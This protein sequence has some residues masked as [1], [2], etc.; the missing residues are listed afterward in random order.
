MPRPTPSSSPPPLSRSPAFP[1]AVHASHTSTA[2]MLL[3]HTPLFHVPYS[4]CLDRLFGLLLLAQT[5]RVRGQR[6]GGR[7]EKSAA[8]RCVWRGRRRSLVAEERLRLWG[9]IAQ[10]RRYKSAK[11]VRVA[12]RWTLD[13]PSIRVLSL[14]RVPSV[15]LHSLV[16][17]SLLVPFSFTFIRTRRRCPRSTEY[18]GR[19]AGGQGSVPR[20]NRMEGAGRE[21]G[22]MGVQTALEPTE[23]HPTQPE[24][25]A[26]P[27]PGEREELGCG[28]A[29]MTILSP[30]FRSPRQG[31]RSAAGARKSPPLCRRRG[32]GIGGRGEVQSSGDCPSERKQYS[33]WIVESLKPRTG[34]RTSRSWS[35]STLRQTYEGEERG[36]CTSRGGCT[37]QRSVGR[38]L[39]Q[40]AGHARRHK[41]A[42]ETFVTVGVGASNFRQSWR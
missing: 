13:G 2:H 39:A 20:A 33:T 3:T 22:S 31:E 21:V 8:L 37:L 17:S 5:R 34:Y 42:G 14:P 25:R 19:R 28:D 12:K 38:V 27:Y 16:L 36:R 4:R 40:E 18:T 1:S 7:V 32:T 35:K 23:H 24:E 15:P 30:N 41:S 26:P 9:Y 11:P 29:L 10:M 6:A